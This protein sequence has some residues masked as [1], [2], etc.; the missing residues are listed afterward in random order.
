[1]SI[2]PDVPYM[3]IAMSTAMLMPI[4]FMAAIDALVRGS[5]ALERYKQAGKVATYFFKSSL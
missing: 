5:F 3:R 4:F 2:Y 1:M